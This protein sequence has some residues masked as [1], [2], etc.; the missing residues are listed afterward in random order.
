MG[1][2]ATD[3]LAAA[4]HLR[5][6]ARQLPIVPPRDEQRGLLAGDLGGTLLERDDRRVISETSSPTSASAIARR[7]SWRGVGNG[8]GTQ[9]YQSVGHREG[10]V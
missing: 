6:E 2:L 5:H 7:I 10:R 3:D 4:R 8:V 9:V 1:S